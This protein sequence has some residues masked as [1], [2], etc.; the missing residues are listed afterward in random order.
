MNAA[1][2]AGVV[3]LAR[4]QQSLS[5]RR[6]Y[7]IP[8]LFSTCA[9]SIHRVIHVLCA[10]GSQVCPPPPEEQLASLCA[11]SCLQH[12]QCLTDEGRRKI[13]DV[14]FNGYLWVLP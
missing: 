5:S 11:E 8:S 13:T 14:T 1:D 6:M 9:E 2:E 3:L 12:P 7:R 10:K 4:Y